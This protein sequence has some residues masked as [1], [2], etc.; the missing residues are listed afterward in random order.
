MSSTTNLFSGGVTHYLSSDIVILVLLFVFFF[1]YALYLG[2]GAIISLILAFY[3]A[4]FFYERFPFV[5]SAMLLKGDSLILLNKVGIFLLF[6]VPLTILFGRYVFHDSGYGSM[7]YARM[8]GYALLC[9]VIVLIF[10]Y[11]IIS[12]DSIHNFSSQI[13]TL[14]TGSDRIFYW[15]IAPIAILFFL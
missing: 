2:K 6:L 1:I 4:Q 12:L 7:H 3:P 13:D 11:S 10:S 15:N 8:A 14:F 5:D 9:V